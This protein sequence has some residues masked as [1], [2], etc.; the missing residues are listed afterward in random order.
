MPSLFGTDVAVNPQLRNVSRSFNG[1]TV[2]EYEVDIGVDVSGSNGPDGAIRRVLDVVAER[3]TVIMVSELITGS[4][5][6]E[7]NGAFKV[8]VEGDF[9]E[10]TYDGT[11]SETFAVYLQSA[12]RDLGANV[13]QE[14]IDVSNTDVTEATGSPYFADDVE[15]DY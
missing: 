12:I 5:N 1:K 15:A 7:A 10:D 6:S 2:R 11:N 4:Q 3:A 14:D 13:G 8:F 9:P